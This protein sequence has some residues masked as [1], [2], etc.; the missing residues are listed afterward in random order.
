VCVERRTG[1]EGDTDRLEAEL[2]ELA[3]QHE[4]TKLVE[5]V[6]FIGRL[7]VDRRHNAKIDRPRLSR[8]L[9]AGVDLD[10]SGGQSLL[11]ARRRR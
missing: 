4:S 8:D 5:R 3:R 7:P 11:G 2:L 9:T 1:Y 10:A 6:V